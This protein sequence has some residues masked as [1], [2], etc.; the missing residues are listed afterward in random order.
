MMLLAFATVQT[1]TQPQWK[2]H[3]A[4]EDA[5]GAKDTIWFIW[6]TTA[7]FYGA[8]T[9]LGEISVNIDHSM[10]SV[11]TSNHGLTWYDTIKIVA[12]PYD[13][14]F[15]HSIEAIN[16]ELPITISW[17]SALLQANW[18]PPHPVGWVNHA[19]IYNDYF[20]LYP[21]EELIHHLDMTL[22]DHVIAPDPENEDPWA[23]Q[24]WVH[25]PMSVVLRQDPAVLVP[26]VLIP[27]NEITLYPNP[28]KSFLKVK[29]KSRITGMQIFDLNGT[30]LIHSEYEQFTP[31]IDLSGL[32]PGIY[33]IE[34]ITIQRIYHYKKFVKTN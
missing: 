5:T 11:W 16:F 3:V 33:I 34:L 1:N 7:T 31:T 8:D 9:A 2:F 15:G 24:E 26:E 18:L 30:C 13:R 14:S 19:R 25:F 21:N 27:P 17:D 23:W 22:D 32:F 28:A 4:F 20:F 12:H 6:D 10:F 29:T